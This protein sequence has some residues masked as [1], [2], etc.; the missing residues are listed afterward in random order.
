MDVVSDMSE[1]SDEPDE[2]QDDE[3]QEVPAAVRKLYNFLIGIP[4]PLTESRTRNG[5][6]NDLSLIHI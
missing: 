6:T 1:V 2:D 3:A 4:Y 5:T